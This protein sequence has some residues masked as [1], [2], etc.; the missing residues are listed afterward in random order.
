MTEEEFVLEIGR[1]K[2]RKS[3][4]EFAVKFI[5]ESNHKTSMTKTMYTKGIVDEY[6]KLRVKNPLLIEIPE[7]T[8]N[9]YLNLLANSPES[10]INCPGRKQGYYY[11]AIL[12]QIENK[13][14]DND[15]VLKIKDEEKKEK[16]KGNLIEKDM[17]PYLEQ[18]LFEV[19]NERVA[20]ISNRRGQGKWAN[21]DLVGFKIDYFFQTPQVE[22]TT[23]EA[24]ILINDWEKWIFEA[25][26]HTVFSNRSYFAFIHSD[27]HINKL[28]NEL[29][30]YAK[31]FGVGVLIVAVEPK[32]WVKIQKGEQFVLNE[33]NHRI[34]EYVPAPYNSPLL[35]FQKKF[36]E[37][38]GVNDQK[39][40]LT[41]GKSLEK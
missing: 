18:W 37:S 41:F 17:Y 11:D 31:K 19:E 33:D 1:I 10:K 7:N 22:L 36:L 16:E 29:R 35:K 2:D 3:Q 9:V 27:E 12:E 32:D 24:K 4:V 13:T 8:I 20:D 34:V 5:L 30:H 40:L 23:I 39:D 28:P 21:P 25:V 38:L 14:T 15:E 6:N 26:A